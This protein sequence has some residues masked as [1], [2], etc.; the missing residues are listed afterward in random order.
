MDSHFQAFCRTNYSQAADGSFRDGRNKVTP[1]SA[2]EAF[3]Y[4]CFN[5]GIQFDPSFTEIRAQE[6]LDSMRNQFLT[7]KERERAA[8]KSKD[9]GPTPAEI[10]NMYFADQKQHWKISPTWGEIEYLSQDMNSCPRP[11]DLEEMARFV[12]VWAQNRGVAASFA[13]VK[14]AL[15]THASQQSAVIVDNIFRAIGY[16]PAYT[17]ECDRLLDAI[18]DLLQITE[19]KP[20]F[21]CLM[22]HWI[23]QV[24]R[25]I[26]GYDVVWEIWLNFFGAP[27]VGKTTL[28]R[29]LCSVIADFYGEPSISVLGDA[30]RERD[31]FTRY[32][33]LNFDELTVGGSSRFL[34]DEKAVPQ[35]LQRAIKQI[36]TQK[37][38]L[39]RTMGGQDQTNRR[40]TFSAIS[41]AN[42]HLYDIVYDETGMRRFFEF[43]CTKDNKTLDSAYYNFKDQLQGNLGCIWCG[44]DES[45]PHGYFNQ[46]C[47]EWAEIREIQNSYYPTKTTTSLWVED[48]HVVS[49]MQSNTMDMY[50][51]Y[52]DWCRE[53][54]YK[55]RSQR[56]WMED[57]QH[58]IPGSRTLRRNI[59]I[60]YAPSED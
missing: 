55:A 44:V 50:G 35:D 18:H 7:D 6:I 2:I 12:T 10:L 8:K 4:Y 23:W 20:V 27:G 51:D 36:I 21:R 16:N 57:I 47:A 29:A 17:Q 58:I 42:D 39:S 3:K 28:L 34:G 14:M 33:V 9:R 41:C 25:K 60:G 54:G 40:L 52:S 24:K 1:K 38:M 15:S 30:T 53:R 48:E 56:S 13:L 32:Y 43:H 31:K 37:K 45:Q 22:K 11:S 26:R 5:T 49:G 46:D 59:N 19:T